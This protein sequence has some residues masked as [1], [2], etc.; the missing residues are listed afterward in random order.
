MDQFRVGRPQKGFSPSTLLSSSI[1]R[2]SVILC[3]YLSSL[4]V[5]LYIY[6]LLYLP[7]AYS[8]VPVYCASFTLVLH[9]DKLKKKQSNRNFKIGV[10]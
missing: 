9:L 8:S 1:T 5:K 7:M 10:V 6:R 2:L 3:L 4:L